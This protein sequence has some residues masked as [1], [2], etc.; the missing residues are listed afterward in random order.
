[1]RQKKARISWNSGIEFNFLS[2][3]HEA[4]WHFE[5]KHHLLRAW[6]NVWGL[7]LVQKAA[8]SGHF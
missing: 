7:S 6:D 2:S 8:I 4:K 5:Q 3:N 1:M